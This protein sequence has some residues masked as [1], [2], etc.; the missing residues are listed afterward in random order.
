MSFYGGRIFVCLFLN[1]DEE[2]HM[3]QAHSEEDSGK[4]RTLR[5][6]KPQT[7]LFVVVVW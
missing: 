5:R 3:Q 4:Q 7:C 6:L 2:T 1:W